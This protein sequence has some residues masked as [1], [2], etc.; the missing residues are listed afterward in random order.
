[1]GEAKRRRFLNQ[2]QENAHDIAR[3]LDAVR[4]RSREPGTLPLWLYALIFV[5]I[6]GLGVWLSPAK[7]HSFYPWECCSSQDCWP[8]G[9]AA[10][11]KEPDPVGTPA[12]W[13]LVDGTVVP[14]L[15]ARP[16]PDGRFHVCRQGGRGDGA[17]ITPRERPPC[18]WAPVP[19]S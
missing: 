4:A 11:A 9:A 17:M 2:Y 12:G 10:D 13:L 6:V 16:S 15:A 8:M 3:D 5:V 14:Y 1:M 18:L 19:G 7:A